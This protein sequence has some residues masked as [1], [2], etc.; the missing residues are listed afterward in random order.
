MSDENTQQLF[1]ALRPALIRFLAARGLGADEAQ[2]AVQD[3]FLK[4]DGMRLDAIADPRA[5][6][7]RAADNLVLDRRRSGFRRL[8]RETRWG[9][10]AAPIGPGI[11]PQPSIETLLIDRERLTAVADALAGLPERTAEIFRRF[12]LLGEPQREIAQT[13]GI[14]LSAVEKHLQ[15]AYAAVVDARRRLDVDFGSPRG[16]SSGG[17]SDAA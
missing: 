13:L 3:L 14:S 6:L 1:L 7:Y 12:R 5:Y 2:D 8:N 10:L 16:H 15:R 17:E 4:L 11:D 9:G